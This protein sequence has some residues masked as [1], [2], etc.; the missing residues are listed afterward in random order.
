MASPEAAVASPAAEET[1]AAGEATAEAEVLP[2][3]PADEATAAEVTAGAQNIANCVNSGNLEGAAALFTTNL[4]QEQFGSSNPYDAVVNLEDFM[5]NGVTFGDV[6]TYADGTSSVDVS[7]MQ[8]EYQAV[9]E[10]WFLIQDGGYWKVDS[11]VPL[12]PAPEGDTAVV[13]VTLTE[14]AME[15]N[16]TSV[17]QMPVIMFHGVN[18]GAEAHEIAIYVLPEGATVEQVLADEDLQN[19]TEFIAQRSYEPGEQG[20]IALLN[21][22]PGKYTLI[23]LFMAPDG[24]FHA[25]KGMY[26]E[27][28]VTAPVS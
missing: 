13:G 1:E 19:Q 17:T 16:A 5:L 26:T 21:L 23:C 14:Y 7:Y 8:S 11:V 12:Q 4:L 10:R 24:E 2:A 18:A 25:A 28:E 15:P 6:S 9:A 27:I 3:T 22:P 20:D